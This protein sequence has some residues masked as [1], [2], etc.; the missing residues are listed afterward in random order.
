MAVLLSARQLRRL[1]KTPGR[2]R[3][4]RSQ[5]KV[6][7]PSNLTSTFASMELPT[8]KRHLMTFFNQSYYTQ[9]ATTRACDSTPTLNISVDI[10]HVKKCIIIIII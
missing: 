2:V 6:S 3:M 4:S 1:E 7:L 9:P 10:W 5:L 8:F